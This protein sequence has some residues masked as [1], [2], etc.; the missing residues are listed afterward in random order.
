MFA[1]LQALFFL[2]LF[3][4][5]PPTPK[6][7][8]SSSSFLLT[9]GGALLQSKAFQQNGR[10]KR[11]K[12]GKGGTEW[13]SGGGGRRGQ[14][15]TET[16]LLL[17]SSDSTRV[18]SISFASAVPD[19]FSLP[20]FPR[21]ACSSEATTTTPTAPTAPAPVPAG[22]GRRP[23]RWWRRRR[24]CFLPPSLLGR[25]VGKNFFPPSFSLLPPFLFPLFQTEPSRPSFSP[26]SSFFPSSHNTDLTR[27]TSGE[28]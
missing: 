13:G 18:R 2:F 9:K 8:S 7:A 22:G 24:P 16:P 5:S 4:F 19:S 11:G 15:G 10:T 26:L 6:G 1:Q 12:G 14:R 3:P 20:S 21:R 28:Q 17:R 27:P 25:S 23:P